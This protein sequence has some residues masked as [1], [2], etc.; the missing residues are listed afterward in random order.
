MIKFVL[1]LIF[2]FSITFDAFSQNLEE[3]TLSELDS[4]VVSADQQGDFNTMLQYA[5]KGSQLALSQNDN[6]PD[7]LYTSYLQS[8]GLSYEMLG[9]YDKAYSN[10]KKAADIL[11]KI[12]GTQHPLYAT[13]LANIAAYYWVVGN[14]QKSETLYLNAQK[15][16]RNSIG[17]NNQTFTYIQND[18]ALLYESMGA[19]EEAEILYLKNIEYEKRNLTNGSYSYASSLNNLA[20][21][22]Y[23]MNQLEKAEPLFL[24]TKE[25]WADLLGKESPDYALVTNNL[26]LL[27]TQKGQFYKSAKLYSEAVNLNKIIYGEEHPSYT[28]TLNNLAGCY[29]QLREYAKA[30]K[31]YLLVQ[32]IWS[33][34][35]AP[36][37]PKQVFSLNNLGF[38]YLEMKDY[39][40]AKRVFNKA[41]KILQEGQPNY[42]LFTLVLRNASH[43]YYHSKQEE[44][45]LVY[46]IASLVYGTK[47]KL[48]IFDI[49]PE[50]IQDFRLTEDLIQ[51]CQTLSPKDIQR[52]GKLDYQDPSASNHT[53]KYL[54]A[55]TKAQY[56]KAIEAGSTDAAKKHLLYNYHLAQAAVQ[57][58]ETTLMHFSE[59]KDKLNALR[60]NVI[61]STFGMNAAKLLGEEKYIRAAFCFIE[62]NKSILLTSAFQGD[63]AQA[64]MGL[65]DSIAQQEAELKTQKAILQKEQYGTSDIEASNA[66]RAKQNQLNLNI[67]DFLK[68]IEKEYPQYHTL[69]YKN[70]ISTTEEIQQSLDSKTA[71]LEYFITDSSTF[72]F[73]ITSNQVNIIPI[74]FSKKIINQKAKELRKALTSYQFLIEEPSV[75]YQNYT[76]V[77]HW[78]Y[79][80]LVAPA[81]Q[82]PSLENLII[83]T[84]G[85]LGHLPFE[86]FLTEYNQ[87]KTDYN[88]L[89]YLINQYNISY[90]YSATLWKENL[91]MPK[92]VNNQ[93]L[94][95]CASSYSSP[96]SSLLDIRSLYEFKIRSNL[97]VLSAAKEEVEVLSKDFKGL[98]LTGAN[99]TEA[100]FKKN[101]PNYSVIHLA[102]HG[103]LHR[104]QPILSSL[105]FTE[106]Q[107]TLENN[108]LQAYEIAH[109][110]LNADLVVLSSCETG[111]G[112][113][114]QG[115]GILS[116]ARSFM[117]AGT[118]SLIVSL[119]QVND[120]ST[121][122][123]MQGLYTYLS[124]GY[125]KDRALSQAKLDYIKKAKDFAAHPA[126]WS[127]FIQLG[128]ASPIE[129]KTNLR[130][131]WFFPALL[132][133]ISL[134]IALFWF[135]FKKRKK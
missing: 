53:F 14:Y 60:H 94:L 124:Q 83:I 119:W 113:F 1:F 110:K 44:I 66:L 13:A 10:Y 107:D 134:M 106:D 73:T 95:A 77:A 104:R 111:Y 74:E 120:Q 57:S 7:T 122:F 21:I 100:N 80:N 35:Y 2:S 99:S 75:A 96:D 56:Q 70:I 38:L 114:E 135:F 15:I 6:V 92:K 91:K 68:V 3:I 47:N 9:N 133:L 62:Q 48:P 101:A 85:A 20:S 5:K 118:P 36:K 52:F 31:T 112:K 132:G 82:D 117:Y 88:K 108:F 65:P 58:N 116:L 24:Q 90:S 69:K 115:E 59:N 50:N 33:K 55:I 105:A 103:I 39:D 34:K 128:D 89:N 43:L 109:L 42:N 71:L 63:K 45:A 29:S 40:K 131:H 51:F 121:A 28:L 93:Q 67:D 64:I 123:I 46:G 22:Y 25:I 127:P 61:F 72:L 102:M 11:E 87:R 54:L 26:A 30:E 84:D 19:Y 81:L 129:L 37:H 32:K 17:E 18:L 125:S 98:F 130:P 23:L 76:S 16:C 8:I 4:L 27:Y 41:F 78:F 49:F 97:E 79:K 86:A 126:F 12:V